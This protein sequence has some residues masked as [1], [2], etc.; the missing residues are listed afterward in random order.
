MPTDEDPQQDAD[1]LEEAARA[2]AY[3][4]RA[5]DTPESTYQV[6]GS[7]HLTLSRIQQSLSQLATWHQQHGVLAAAD[8][9][10]REAGNDSAQKAAGWLLMAAAGAG[11][12]IDLVM[13]APTE[14]GQIAWQPTP[15]VR[16]VLA[17]RE[18]SLAPDPS[19]AEKRPERGGGLSR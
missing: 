12:V 17:E 6:L 11:Q 8:D 7:V 16:A 4:T 3:A 2:L 18:V 5:I 9:G 14:N 19:P 15:D 10:N 1:E 13:A